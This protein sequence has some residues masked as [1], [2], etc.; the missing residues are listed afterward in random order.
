MLPLV[1]G[2]L[3]R[4]RVEVPGPRPV[5]EVILIGPLAILLQHET[6]RLAV[7]RVIADDV[8]IGPLLLAR[9]HPAFDREGVFQHGQVSAGVDIPAV[10]A[11]FQ[12]LA[13]PPRCKRDVAGA[14]PVVP[15]AGAIGEAAIESVLQEQPRS[16]L[17]RAAGRCADYDQCK[18]SGN[19]GCHEPGSNGHRFTSA[20]MLPRARLE[21]RRSV[22]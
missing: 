2:Q 19:C 12:T 17:R 18:D 3:D 8:R 4:L 22:A 1:R 5:G 9:I 11:E 15:V 10:P 7:I 16:P 21:A 6:V 14:A 13:L 20:A